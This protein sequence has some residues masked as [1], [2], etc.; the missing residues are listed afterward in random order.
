VS[1]SVDKVL[2]LLGEDLMLGVELDGGAEEGG[3]NDKVVDKVE[4]SSRLEGS[5]SCRAWNWFETG[6]SAMKVF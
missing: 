4:I 3:S 6:M 1:G 5:R 2:D